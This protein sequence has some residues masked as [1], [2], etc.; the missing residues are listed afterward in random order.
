MN[1]EKMIAVNRIESE[2]KIKLA[3]MAIEQLIE[4][5]EYPSVT[6]LVKKTG[7]SR[8]FFYKNPE[9]RSR[10][11]AAVQSPNVSCRRIWS[12]SKDSKNDNTE[13]LQMDIMEYKVRNRSLSQENEELRGQIEELKAILNAAAAETAVTGV[14]MDRKKIEDADLDA[15]F[16]ERTSGKLIFLENITTRV[17]LSGKKIEVEVFASKGRMKIHLIQRATKVK[18]EEKVRWK[19]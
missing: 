14:E 18:P 4:R 19:K 15:F 16:R 11:D 8:G 6:L 3:T 17:D 12:E 9:V 7:L 13:A 10:L 1:Y 2:Q 5:G